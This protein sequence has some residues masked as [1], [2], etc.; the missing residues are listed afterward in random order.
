MYQLIYSL[1]SLKQLKKLSKELQVRIISALERIRVR[2]Y[3]HVKKLVASPY[4]RLRVGDYRV[5]MD[6]K[7]DKLLIFVIGVG[8]TTS[9]YNHKQS[10]SSLCHIDL[11]FLC[12][13]KA[14]NIQSC[15]QVPACSA[16]GS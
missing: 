10:H 3:P 12:Y 1:Q 5:I 8:H 15:Y 7:E 13:V 14:F 11:H 16:I 6:I 9:I 2:P 4:Y